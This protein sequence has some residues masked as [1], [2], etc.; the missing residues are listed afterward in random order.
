M[1]RHQF[2]H[3]SATNTIIKNNT[4]HEN[5]A[6]KPKYTS[7]LSSPHPLLKT[8][9]SDAIACV[10]GKQHAMYLRCVVILRKWN[11]SEW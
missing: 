3:L 5:I 10:N 6:T 2:L 7:G 8:D 9:L 1:L 4:I 11:V